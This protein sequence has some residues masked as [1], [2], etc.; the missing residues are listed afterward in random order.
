[1]INWQSEQDALEVGK[2]YWSEKS[3]MFRKGVGHRYITF[4]CLQKIMTEGGFLARD[5]FTL[6]T[7]EELQWFEHCERLKKC[8]SFKDWQLHFQEPTIQLYPLN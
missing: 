1:M 3:V 8:I 7:P 2:V 5:T 6:P 4:L